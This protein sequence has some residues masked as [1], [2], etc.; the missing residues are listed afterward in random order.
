MPND[1]TLS[2]QKFMNSVSYMYISFVDYFKSIPEFRNLCIE[3]KISLLKSNFNQIFRLNNALVVHATGAVED[4]STVVFK[5]VFPPDLYSELC[6]CV[7][8]IF[9]FVYDPILLKLLFIV[10]MFSP[11]L[12]T[13]YNIN[14]KLIN[15]KETL[16]IQNSYIELLW[17][18]MLYRYSTLEQSIRILTSFITR[19]LRSQIVTEELAVFVSKTMSNQVDQLEPIMKAMWLS[20]KK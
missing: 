2:L 3:T 18:Y 14:E 8:N 1:N 17:R 16:S 7:K 10:L 12:C 19:L 4:T 5:N 20:E 13:R 9:P 6:Y 11:S 15:T